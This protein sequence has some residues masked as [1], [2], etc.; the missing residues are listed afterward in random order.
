M[1]LKLM[2]SAIALAAGMSQGALAETVRIA[3]H[4]QARIDA[5]NAVIPE[6]EQQT[7]VDI[8][9]VE[10]PGPDKE[11]LSKILT[12]LSAGTGPDI[13]S[14]PAMSQVTDFSTAGYLEDV[15][16]VVQS[17]EAWPQLYQVAKDLTNADG[18]TYVMPTQMAVLE[19][20]YRKDLLEKA[21]IS[22][23]QPKSWD[24]LLTRAQ[25]IKQKTGAYG[26]L[27]PMGATWG[28]GSWIEGFRPMLAAS[29]TPEILTADGKFNLTSK[30]VGEVFSFYE[31]LIKDELLPV[32]PLLGP[33]PWVIPKYEMFPAGELMATTCGSWCY[34]GDFGPSSKNPIDNVADNVG[35]W[36]VPRID[37][38]EPLVLAGPNHPWA[39][40]ANAIDMDAAN[41]VLAAM[42]SINLAV[43]YSTATGNLPARK[44]VADAPEFQ[45]LIPL[46]RI[47]GELDSGTDI[48]TA[49]GFTTVM[50][51]INRA[52]EALL[53]GSTDAAGAQQMLVDYVKSG[54]GD[55]MVN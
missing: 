19:L 29:S 16:E 23:E 31:K 55:D 6:L 12:E 45:K 13:F 34:F 30:G 11:Y 4:R 10:Y 1:K 35:T 46:P 20:Y 3:E 9:L 54:L 47:I 2:I 7:G 5:L 22:T 36:M 41:K 39:V 40:N 53:L 17:S 14:L 15:T 42:G 8:E 50:E 27:I 28:G 51:G 43:S 21:G 25:E 49:S 26:L 52:T 37:G 24:E 44:D 32:D 38:G 48:V 33:D 18:K